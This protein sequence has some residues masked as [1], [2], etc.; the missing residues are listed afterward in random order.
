MPAAKHRGSVPG[1]LIRTAAA[2]PR[3]AGHC[4]AVTSICGNKSTAGTVTR[5]CSRPK[6]AVVTEAITESAVV[7][8]AIAESAMVPE[9]IAKSTVIAEA[10]A[11]SVVPPAPF[12]ESTA[13]WEVA[14][15]PAN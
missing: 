12:A 6:S 9:A 13:K 14:A 3:A 2:K 4:R 11:K 7:T 10:V 8:E 5:P 1:G 15:T